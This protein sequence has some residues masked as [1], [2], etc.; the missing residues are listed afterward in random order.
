MYV[1]SRTKFLREVLIITNMKQKSMQF[2]F[3]S[4]SWFSTFIMYLIRVQYR[5]CFKKLR[6]NYFNSMAFWSQSNFSKARLS[7]WLLFVQ[8]EKYVNLN[9]TALLLNYLC[10]IEFKYLGKNTHLSNTKYKKQFFVKYI[11]LSGNCSI[12]C[13]SM[14]LFLPNVEEEP[15]LSEQSCRLCM[16]IPKLEVWVVTIISC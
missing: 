10:G 12:N 5:N 9:K 7:P 1:Y 2:L 11:S 16:G 8:F 3:S 13:Q 14:F 15:V 4:N 6:F